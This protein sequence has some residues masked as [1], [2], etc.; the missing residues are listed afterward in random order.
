MKRGFHGRALYLCRNLRRNLCRA[1]ADATKTTTP[2][3]AQ[4][5][6]RAL[7]RR[8]RAVAAFRRPPSGARFCVA[9]LP[10]VPPA[11]CGGSGYTGGF[12]PSPRQAGLGDISGNSG[13]EIA[14]ARSRQAALMSLVQRPWVSL[15]AGLPGRLVRH[16]LSD[17]LSSQS[18]HGSP[19]RPI[20]ASPR[21][22]LYT[23]TS[24][25]KRQDAR[26]ASASSSSASRSDRVPVM[27]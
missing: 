5:L 26:F 7:R 8:T 4:S 25:K 22:L 17:G 6:R 11:R 3:S 1:I 23:Y 2:R 20:P 9:L 10:P 16:S 24:T 15:S 12:N 14:A 21:L 19:R 13:N 27:R 18:E